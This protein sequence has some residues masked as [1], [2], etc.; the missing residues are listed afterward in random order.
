M[1]LLRAELTRK[2]IPLNLTLAAAEGLFREAAAG[3]RKNGSYNK[4]PLKFTTLDTSDVSCDTVRV[5]MYFKGDVIAKA[6][7]QAGRAP[8]AAS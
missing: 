2:A 6:H 5:F 4:G 8:T 3:L 7:Y 1:K